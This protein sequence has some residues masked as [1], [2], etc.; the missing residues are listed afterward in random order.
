MI[1]ELRELEKLQGELQQMIDRQD[2]SLVFKK[3]LPLPFFN[4][5][6][7]LQNEFIAGTNDHLFGQRLE[8][9]VHERVSQER[10]R[11]DA[12]LNSEITT[13]EK[14]FEALKQAV[15]K[16]KEEQADLQQEKVALKKELEKLAYQHLKEENLLKTA[17]KELAYAQQEKAQTQK[18]IEKLA[19]HKAYA[20]QNL[21]KTAEDWLKEAESCKD[22]LFIFYYLKRALELG[23]DNINVDNI[24]FYRLLNIATA[25]KISTKLMKHGRYVKMKSFLDDCLDIIQKN[26]FHQPKNNTLIYYKG[27]ILTYQEKYEEALQCFRRDDEIH[28]WECVCYAG[29]QN[30]QATLQCLKKIGKYD[31]E[32]MLAFE[33]FDWLQ[34]D[35]DFQRVIARFDNEI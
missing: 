28:W 5:Y 7:R 11:L 26:I 34:G 30:K 1:N 20:L 4:G 17:Q 15:D 2:F 35:V 32:L 22:N 23:I 33:E 10:T 18:E 13:K 25:V 6:Q 14:E 29:L 8:S 24:C 21:D 16:L 19:S 9:F 27:L 12:L 31:L 3:I